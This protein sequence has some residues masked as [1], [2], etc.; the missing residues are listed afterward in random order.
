MKKIFF[1][2]LFCAAYSISLA[3]P[4]A[5]MGEQKVV[6]PLS[7]DTYLFRYNSDHP[8]G[9]DYAYINSGAGSAQGTI[10]GATVGSTIVH[11]GTYSLLTDALNE[12]ILWSSGVSGYINTSEGS[13]EIWVYVNV[14]EIT[15]SVSFFEIYPVATGGNN[16]IRSIMNTDGTVYFRHEGNNVVVSMSSAA[17]I[18]PQTWTRIRYRWSV[19]GNVIGIQVGETGDWGDDADADAVTAFSE[20]PDTFAIG[21][22]TYNNV[23]DHEL[24]VDDFEVIN[25]YN[26]FN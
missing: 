12:R 14:A 24:Y 11:S 21:E 4:V 22:Y 25:G 19:S 10:S 17:V 1:T 18:P 15:G 5:M 13:L 2:L 9:T 6:S 16:M 3:N 26:T 7:G 23:A 8:S 20:S